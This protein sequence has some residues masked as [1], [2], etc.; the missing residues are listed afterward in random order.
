MR[1]R[2]A[3]CRHLR[4]P[5]YPAARMLKDFVTVYMTPLLFVLQLLG[6][7]GLWSLRKSFP[8]QQDLADL[9]A[10]EEARDRRI[11]SLELARELGPSASDIAN[12]RLEMERTRGDIRECSANLAGSEGLITRQERLV[13]MLL[14]HQLQKD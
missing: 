11:H 2:G 7:W 4:L 14:E 1:D 8:T 13:S 9:R 5:A 12:M 10:R 6:T 3:L